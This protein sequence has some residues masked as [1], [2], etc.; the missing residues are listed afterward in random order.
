MNIGV[1]LKFVMLSCKC[2]KGL[3]GRTRLNVIIVIN[4]IKLCFLS[5][6]TANKKRVS[7][8]S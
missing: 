4:I 7:Y 5:Y 8:N 2:E 3:Y 1:I 6:F